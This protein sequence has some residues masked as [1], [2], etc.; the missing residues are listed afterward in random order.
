MVS[1]VASNS[2]LLIAIREFR[3]TKGDH[4]HGEYLVESLI[5]HVVSDG[6]TVVNQAVV[7]NRYSDFR[8]LH[9]VLKDTFRNSKMKRDALERTFFPAKKYYGNLSHKF[10]E[11]RRADLALYFS[12]L[13]L[14]S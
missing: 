14:H 3:V 10:L 5:R 4:P 8:R 6:H 1:V 13:L 11:Q 9:N 2:N 12:Q 7:W